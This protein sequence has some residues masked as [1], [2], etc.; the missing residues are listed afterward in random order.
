MP[1][2]YRRWG[3]PEVESGKYRPLHPCECFDL[4]SLNGIVPVLSHERYED[5]LSPAQRAD[6]VDVVFKPQTTVFCFP[7]I[8]AQGSQGAARLRDFAVTRQRFLEL[9]CAMKTCVTLNIS[10]PALEHFYSFFF[11]SQP[12]QAVECKRLVKDHVRFRPAIVGTGRKI[13]ARLGSY[14]AVHVRRNDFIAQYPWQSMSADRILHNLRMRVPAG[15]RLYVA[16]DERDRNFF[17]GWRTHYELCLIEDLPSLTSSDLSGPMIACIEQ[18]I[19]A[20]AETFIGTKL[21]TYSAYITRLRGYWG[22]SDQNIYF[23]DGSPGSEIDGLGSPRFSWMN[24]VQ[25]G[26]PLWGREFREA[27][28]F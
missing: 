12:R 3:E 20:F 21:S 8:P 7:D 6:R 14:C 13:A 19:C 10:E 26:N 2:E 15:N 16:S 23:T 24:W 27:W 9:S 1:S 17:A 22:A 4:D 28:E 25:S 5:S 11:F 18:M